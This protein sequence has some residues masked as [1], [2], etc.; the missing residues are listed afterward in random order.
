MKEISL[1]MI[2]DH[3]DH[4]PYFSCSSDY[5]IRTFVRG[6]E[7]LWARIEAEV[8]EFANQEQALEHFQA[9]FG[10][11]LSE[12]E[13]RCFL[14]EDKHGEAIGTATAWY[15]YVAGEKR[16]RIHWVGI[17]PSYQG[18]KLSKPLL[19][20]VMARLAKDHQKAYLTTQTT[21]YQAV[22]LYLNF[23][24]A[25]SFSSDTS[26]EGWLL[27]EQMLHRKILQEPQHDP[28]QKL[29]T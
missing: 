10:P 7:R 1:E 2:R 22:N 17:V 29:D 12:L 5:T 15:G 24:F 21:S 26:K 25:P 14:L 28:E 20:A 18:R 27:M 9:E 19:S 11:F 13:D 6:D 23:G 4:F 8:G 16:G 3:M